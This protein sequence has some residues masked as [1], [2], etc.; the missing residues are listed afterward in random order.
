MIN[1]GSKLPSTTQPTKRNLVVKDRLSLVLELLWLLF[2]IIPGQLFLG[3]FRKVFPPPGK[4]LKG[5]VVIVS[6][7]TN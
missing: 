3:V 4:S 1:E 5:Q 7:H 6:S 2:I